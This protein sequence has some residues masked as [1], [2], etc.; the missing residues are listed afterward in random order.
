MQAL[1]IISTSAIK[2]YLLLQH[3]PPQVW[4]SLQ[5]THFLGPF[6]E[7]S[8]FKSGGK[9]PSTS[10]CPVI[11]RASAFTLPALTPDL[12]IPLACGFA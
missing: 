8:G 9:V 2:L 3:H 6:K 5:K 12:S 1:P 11:P 4:S 7:A 10:H